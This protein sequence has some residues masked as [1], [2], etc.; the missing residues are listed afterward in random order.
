MMR[1]ILLFFTF[2]F[3]VSSL[4][5]QKNL[6]LNEIWASATFR[7]EFVYGIQSMND[8]LHYSTIS[9]DNEGNPTI[10]MFSYTTGQKVKT[11]FEFNKKSINGLPL[12]PND[13][14]FSPDETKLLLPTDEESIYRHSTKAA[15]VIIDL[16]KQ[17]VDYLSSGKQQYAGFSPDGKNVAFVRDNNLFVKNLDS[18]AEYTVTS[19]G[20]WNSIINGACDWVYE[21][22][23]SFAQAW[24]WN[25][26]GTYLAYYR[27]DESAVKEFNMAMYGSLY[28]TDYKYKYPKAGET[29]STVS[30]WTY[31]VQTQKVQKMETGEDANQYIPRIKWTADAKQLSITRLNRLQN[32]LEFFIA[33]AENGKLKLLF[34]EKSPT[35]VDI[36]DHYHF[37]KD[38][39]NLVW[40]S[41]L[42][43]YNHLYMIE[44]ATGK[45]KA[46]TK[47]NWDI[48]DLCGV[49]EASQMA[50]FVAANPSPM[51]KQVF[52]VGLK[53]GKI[54]RITTQ[55][56]S[57][58]PDF[59]S[60]FQFFID[61]YSSANSPF[62]F[63]LFD[64]TG[65]LVREIESNK[66]LKNKLATYSLQPKEFI[67][68][69]IG[70]GI[71]LNAWMIKPANFDANKKY[72]VFM[73]IYGGPGHNTVVDSYEHSNYL[74]HQLLA[75]K[76][77]I[78]VSVD[79][80]GTG[81]R[82]EAFK[83]S[84]YKQLGKLEVEDQIAAAKYLGTLPY[85]DK[86]RIGVQGWSFGGYLSSLCITKGADVFKMAIAVAPVTNWRFYDSIYT[87]RFLQTPQENPSG[88]DDNSPINHVSRLKGKYLLVHGTA[89]DNVHFQNS[90]EMVNALVKA[91]KQFDLFFYPDKNHSI[92]GGIARLHLYT[93]MTKFIEDNL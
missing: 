14:T 80:R 39:K 41:E 73:T 26:D 83:K 59:S 36:T 29:N 38:G 75:Q 44:L 78:V 19:D 33:N 31:N 88:Y 62:E 42:E 48:T 55:K 27:F 93:K 87:E 89:D 56:G 10:D 49:D 34:E 47:G 23:F 21:E 37:L 90:V 3:T 7:P 65:K 84:T 58:K 92:A 30:I 81:M 61:Q 11:I 32:H 54:N 64:R 74:W 50:Y 28:P 63:H 6:T 4:S 91:N 72:P 69:P 13:Y 53:S 60:T 17:T 12:Q 57:H 2:S 20:K 52:S 5:A 79:N 51:E 86:N 77:Y 40:T 9:A 18:G 43:G 24:Q 85:I 76:G 8:G 71:E 35:Y 68:L 66:G 45:K 46:I 22:E 15:Y 16:K 70:E 82:G 1:A 67:K 25:A